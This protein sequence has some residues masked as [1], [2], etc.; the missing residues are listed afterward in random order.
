MVGGGGT[1]GSGALQSTLEEE[2]KQWGQGWRKRYIKTLKEKNIL[3][4][5]H[6]TEPTHFLFGE[7]FVYHH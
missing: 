1:K 3:F 7:H 6:S 2:E 5:Y 4:L